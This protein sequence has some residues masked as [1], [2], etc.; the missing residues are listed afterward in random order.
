MSGA[1]E[2][3]YS[4]ACQGGLDTTTNTQ[5]LLQ[6]P[7]WATRLVNFEAS[8]DGGYRRISGYIP[9]GSNK[10]PGPEES[11]IKGV[12]IINNESFLLCHEDKVYF[13]YDCVN[14]VNIARADT[15]DATYTELQAKAEIPRAQ[16]YHYDFEIFRQGTTIIVMG[17]CNDHLPFMFKVTGTTLEDSIYTFQELTLTSG[18]MSG[19]TLSEKHKDQ[20]VIAGM[21]QAPSEIYYSDILKPWDFEGANA[22]AIGFNDTVIGIQMFRGDLIVFCRN[23]IHKVAGLSSG[24]P[25]RE[26]ITTKIGCI[27]GESIQEL[28]GD[29][30]FLSPDGLR[31]LSATTRIGDVNLSALSDSIANR[32]RILN[33]SINEFDVR[34]E[35]LK[36]KVQYRLFFKPKDGIKK[37]SY[38]FAMHMRVD[39]Q[40]G[41]LIP[42]FSELKGFDITA[43]DNGFYRGKEVTVSGDGEGK[44]WYHD[45]GPDFNG[46]FITF[47]YETPYFAMEDPSVRKNIHSLTTYLKLEGDVD[48]NVAL[49][50]D[51]GEP[52][53]YQP[54]PYPT[55]TLLAPAV[56]GEG[57]YQ[58]DKR[59]GSAKNPIIRTTTEGSGKT[60]AIRIFPTGNRCDPFSLQGFDINYIPAGRI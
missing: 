54:P 38:A 16:S 42:E 20:W 47:L 51:Y 18:S 7:G 6:K 23:S 30:V 32:L 25:Q 59:Y 36:N 39:P 9:I 2:V 46:K 35:T 52:N 1:T 17:L 10:T 56:Y 41:N 45:E 14:F 3:T 44:L 43:I 58:T 37:G 28:A 19:A 21:D 53:T 55:G 49:R 33:I 4:I 15:T 60:V 5:D 11:R 57:I 31:T 40:Y 34:S 27:A 8:N 13:T 50:Y 29:L 22:G 24:S 26:T 48:F 12:K